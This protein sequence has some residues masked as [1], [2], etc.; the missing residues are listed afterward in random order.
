MVADKIQPKPG[1]RVLFQRPNL[2]TPLF[3]LTGA[4]LFATDGAKGE[5][6]DWSEEAT[7]PSSGERANIYR[8]PDAEWGDAVA[9]G[10][11]HALTYPVTVTGALVPVRPLRALL[12][13]NAGPLSR[14][15]ALPVR[16][17]AGANSF[18]GFMASLGLLPYPT[19]NG[20]GGIFFPV[21]TRPSFRMGFTTIHRDGA[22]GL[23]FSC[24]TCHVAS[25]F[26]RPVVGLNNR[27]Q[28]ANSF[29]LRGATAFRAIAAVDA[30]MRAV[31]A[32]RAEITM[33]HSTARHLRFTSATQP[34]ALGLDTSLAQVALSLAKRGLDPDAALDPL[35][36]RN[37]RANLLDSTVA[38]SKPAVWWNLK[39]KTRWLSDASI[40][41]GNPVHTNFLWNEIGRGTD[42]RKLGT[43]LNANQRVVRDLTAAVFA[44][45]A[46]RYTEFFPA[47]A[48]DE[49]A[50]RRGQGQFLKLCARCHGSYAKAWDEPGAERLQGAARFATTRVQYSPRTFAIDVGTD[51]ARA[52]GMAAFGDRLNAL[53]ISRQIRTRVEAQRGYVPPPLVGIWARWPYLHNN[54]VPSLCALLTRS[55]ARPS[56][57]V[58]VPAADPERDF[59]SRCVGYPLDSAAAG[60]WRLRIAHAFDARKAG[61]S[62]RGHDEGIFLE[63]GRELL[64]AAEKL[65]LIEF[66][67]TL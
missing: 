39:Y 40:R 4:T 49:N 60:S 3:L 42:L 36:A 17:A 34:Q 64:S 32:S 48:L 35:A 7:L 33:L 44:T 52:A 9:R 28:R 29:F 59:D 61:L 46:P 51:P 30:S 38:D 50:A 67:K 14:L 58:A 1:G 65:D 57:Y 2:F 10:L 25:L 21:A 5:E 55:E 27:F 6:P 56:R 18:D 41:S 22:E 47:S 37:P 45:Q 66:L 63:G 19:E 26:G 54:S 11:Q 16:R 62:N 8:L 43:W 12:D 23:T 53:R 24:A 13:G 15:M 31:G 20:T